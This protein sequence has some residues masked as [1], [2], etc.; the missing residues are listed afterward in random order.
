MKCLHTHRS[1]T[2]RHEIVYPVLFAFYELDTKLH[3]QVHKFLPRCKTCHKKLTSG[4]WQTLSS[5]AG[6]FFTMDIN[7]AD[8]QTKWLKC[9]F[10]R[11]IWF[12]RSRVNWCIKN[13][14]SKFLL[15]RVEIKICSYFKWIFLKRQFSIEISHRR[16]KFGE[17]RRKFGES[18]RKFGE[19]WQKF[20]KSRRK[21][22]ESQRKF[23]ESRPKFGESRRK[24]VKMKS[25][26]L[27]F[28]LF[29]TNLAKNIFRNNSGLEKV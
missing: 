21:F 17:S 15:R 29:F 19:S 1:F 12:C 20:G 6:T 4:F 27:I 5:L 9:G 16:R 23:G 10:V 25:T 11:S 3:T 13:V 22:G 18:R 26:I 7:I 28:K 8:T 14:F 24:L 2:L